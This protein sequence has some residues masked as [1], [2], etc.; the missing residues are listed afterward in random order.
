MPV[1]TMRFVVIHCSPTVCKIR[2]AA[3][4]ETPGSAEFMSK[5]RDVVCEKLVHRANQYAKRA[6]I[7]A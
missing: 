3:A 1:T 2:H 5:Y 7:T 6:I 4:G